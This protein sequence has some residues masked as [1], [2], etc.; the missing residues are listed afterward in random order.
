MPPTSTLNYA[1]GQT[2][3]NNA[4]VGLSAS[5]ALAVRCS[6]AAGTVHAILDVTGYFE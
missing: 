1:A 6:Q 2:R 5:G 3:A 4:V